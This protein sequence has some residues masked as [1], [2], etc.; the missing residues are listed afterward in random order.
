MKTNK[1]LILA[2]SAIVA[3]LLTSC[4]ENKQ[5]MPEANDENCNSDIV[6]KDKETQHAFYDICL[7]R[8]T[9]KPSTQRAW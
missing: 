3:A 8:G 7:R 9:F 4:G 1:I 6:F 2:L 5:A